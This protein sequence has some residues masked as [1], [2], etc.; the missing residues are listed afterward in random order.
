[1]LLIT[2]SMSNL[3]Y[4]QPKYLSLKRNVNNHP[5]IINKSPLIHIHTAEANQAQAPQITIQGKAT[6][7]PLC[8]F[9]FSPLCRIPTTENKSPTPAR[10]AEHHSPVTYCCAREW[11]LFTSTDW[12][13]AEDTARAT[14]EPIWKAV[15]I[16]F[17]QYFIQG[18]NEGGERITIPPQRLLTFTGTP[19]NMVV[20]A[21]M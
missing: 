9:R 5:K 13:T 14:P 18:N 12:V 7:S 15:L 19:A 2:I 10:P 1:M 21:V 17:C 20:L 6:G 16:C 11:P 3:I 4:K 8:E